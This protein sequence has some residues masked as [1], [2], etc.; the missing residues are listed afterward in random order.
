MKENSCKVEQKD[1]E[2]ENRSEKIRKLEDHPGR[3]A[4]E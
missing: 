3:P 4:F 2:M 1:K